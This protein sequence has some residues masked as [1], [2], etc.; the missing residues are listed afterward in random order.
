MTKKAP[1]FKELAKGTMPPTLKGPAWTKMKKDAQEAAT[2]AYNAAQKKAEAEK[3][4]KDFA[5]GIVAYLGKYSGKCSFG[6]V[7]YALKKG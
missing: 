6:S 1:V 2:K 7:G 5:A 3:I 4:V